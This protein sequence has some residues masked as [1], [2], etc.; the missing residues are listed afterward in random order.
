LCANFLDLE[1]VS[2]RVPATGVLL[3][4][5]P[6]GKWQEAGPGVYNASAKHASLATSPL[7]FD[8]LDAEGLQRADSTVMYVTSEC[9]LAAVATD[10]TAYPVLSTEHTCSSAQVLSDLVDSIDDTA[11]GQVELSFMV[12][13]ITGSSSVQQEVSIVDRLLLGDQPMGGRF[14]LEPPASAGAADPSPAPRMASALRRAV[15][16]VT[17][18]FGAYPEE[19]V[20]PLDIIR[21][22]YDA[23]TE[24]L[25]AFHRRQEAGVAEEVGDMSMCVSF[26]LGEVAG[27]TCMSMH[28][29]M[30]MSVDGRMAMDNESVADM[31][32]EIHLPQYSKATAT[33]HGNMT[34]TIVIDSD[35][36]APMGMYSQV[37][38]QHAYEMG[39][40]K[41]DGRGR[42]DWYFADTTNGEDGMSIWAGAWWHTTDIART[43]DM[44]FR[45]NMTDDDGMQVFDCGSELDWS[46]A[47]ADT[48][49]PTIDINMWM[50][51]WDAP[52]HITFNVEN[53][54]GSPSLYFMNMTGLDYDDVSFPLNMTGWLDL[55]TEVVHA[56]VWYDGDAIFHA[57]GTHTSDGSFGWTNVTFTPGPGMSLEDLAEGLSG[58]LGHWGDMIEEMSGMETVEEA[59]AFTALNTCNKSSAESMTDIHVNVRSPVA[60]RGYGVLAELTMAASRDMDV[61][62]AYTLSEFGSSTLTS[63]LQNETLAQE[64]ATGAWEWAGLKKSITP[65]DQMGG[66][67]MVAHASMN[68]VLHA[69]YGVQGLSDGNALGARLWFDQESSYDDAHMTAIPL[70]YRGSLANWWM[71]AGS[72]ADCTAEASLH[73]DSYTS[74]DARGAVGKLIGGG[75]ASASVEMASNSLNGARYHLLRSNESWPCALA[76]LAAGT[77]PHLCSGAV[78]TAFDRS[79]LSLALPTVSLGWDSSADFTPGVPGGYMGGV[80]FISDTSSQGYEPPVGWDS[81]DVESCTLPLAAQYWLH[82]DADSFSEVR[83]ALGVGS[84]AWCNSYDVTPRID[85]G[86]EETRII[87]S[88]VAS[89]A[90][91]DVRLMLFIEPNDQVA[92]VA[93]LTW[94]DLPAGS[95]WRPVEACGIMLSEGEPEF[96]VAADGEVHW[97]RTSMGA[98]MTFWEKHSAGS[99]A[100]QAVSAAS[101]ALRSATIDTYQTA[102]GTARSVVGT[103]T[104]SGLCASVDSSPRMV[105]HADTYAHAKKRDVGVRIEGDLV[106]D[107]LGHTVVNVTWQG[108]KDL[109]GVWREDAGMGLTTYDGGE[110]ARW[111]LVNASVRGDDAGSWV[112][113]TVSSQDLRV[114]AGMDIP[115]GVDDTEGRW[116]HHWFDTTDH[117]DTDTSSIDLTLNAWFP[118]DG[119]IWERTYFTNFTLDSHRRLYSR[120]FRWNDEPTTPQHTRIMRT[121]D[122]EVAVLLHMTDRMATQHVH[123]NVTGSAAE[124]VILYRAQ[125]WEVRERGAAIERLNEWE[126]ANYSTPTMWPSYSD[127]AA[128]DLLF[129]WDAVPH[130]AFLGN[131]TLLYDSGYWGSD[132]SYVKADQPCI[133][134]AAATWHL[135]G[136]DAFFESMKCDTAS[137]RLPDTVHLRDV[138]SSD[139]LN[140]SVL[141]REITEWEAH[142]YSTSNS[143]TSVNEFPQSWCVE[144]PWHYNQVVVDGMYESASRHTSWGSKREGDE[145]EANWCPSI[146]ASMSPES[147]QFSVGGSW[148]KAWHNATVYLLDGAHIAAG[149]ANW[150]VPQGDMNTQTIDACMVSYVAVEG[151]D[152]ADDSFSLHGHGY[153]SDTA[154]AEQMDMDL[155]LDNTT[156]ANGMSWADTY[157]ETTNDRYGDLFFA[158]QA[159]APAFLCTGVHGNVFTADVLGSSTYGQAPTKALAVFVTE[160]EN[161]HWW[162][163][164]ARWNASDIATGR[165]HHVDVSLDTRALALAAAGG[166]LTAVANLTVWN[167]TLDVVSRATANL[168]LRD[169]WEGSDR[170][171]MTIDA[172]PGLWW[173]KHHVGTT[174]MEMGLEM[175]PFDVEAHARRAGNNHTTVQAVWNGT[176]HANEDWSEAVGFHMLSEEPDNLCA[177]DNVKVSGAVKDSLDGMWVNVTLLMRSH[178]CEEEWYM[179]EESGNW[180]PYEHQESELTNGNFT[181][182]TPAHNDARLLANGLIHAFTLQGFPS[183]PA[184]T[185]QA[186]EAG[187]ALDVRPVQLSDGWFDY[188]HMVGAVHFDEVGKMCLGGDDTCELESEP[189]GGK[190]SVC[191]PRDSA[192]SSP[193]TVP[194]PDPSPSPI[195]SPSPSPAPSPSVG[196]PPSPTPSPSPSAAPA[197]FTVQPSSWSACS[198]A[199]GPSGVQTRTLT[200]LDEDGESVALS[201]CVTAPFPTE[202]ACNRQLCPDYHPVYGEYGEC[203][204]TCGGGEQYRTARC[205]DRSS[206]ATVSASRCNITSSDTY[207]ACNEGTCP[208]FYYTMGPWGRCSLA[209]GG[210][211]QTRAVNCTSST[212]ASTPI[213]A[214]ATDCGDATDAPATGRSCN[215]AP[216]TTYVVTVGSWGICGASGGSGC[217]DNVT[218]DVQ[219]VAIT[220]GERANAEDSACTAAGLSLP[221]YEQDCQCTFCELLELSG[222]EGACSGRGECGGAGVCTCDSGYGGD[223]CHIDNTCNGIVLNG[224]CCEGVVDNDG[225]CCGEGG[226]LDRE[227][228]CCTEGVDA[229]GVCGGSSTAMDI[230]GSCCMTEDLDASGL[231]CDDRID[232]LGICGGVD[233]GVL[234]IEVTVSTDLDSTV[235][236]EDSNADTNQLKAAL[237]AQ[238]ATAL[239]VDTSRVSVRFVASSGRRM[240]RLTEYRYRQLQASVEAVVE[241]QPEDAQTSNFRSLGD[242]KAALQGSSLVTSVAAVGMSATCGND[243]CEAGEAVVSGTTSGTECADDCPVPIAPCPADDDG[244][245]CGGAGQ[246]YCVLGTCECRNGYSGDACSSGCL[247]THVSVNGRCSFVGASHCSDGVKSG[248]ETGMDCGGSCVNDCPAG[249]DRGSTAHPARGDGTMTIVG[250]VV[251]IAAVGGIAALVLFVLRRQRGQNGN[252]KSVSVKNPTIVVDKPEGQAHIAGVNPMHSGSNSTGAAADGDRASL[253]IPLRAIRSNEGGD[254]S[255]GGREG[256]VK[257]SDEVS[258]DSATQD[259]DGPS[260]HYEEEGEDGSPDH[261]EEEEG[262]TLEDGTWYEV[263]TGYRYAPDGTGYWDGDDVWYGYE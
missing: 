182:H 113:M 143:S 232:S 69:G 246:G 197:V 166:V 191:T 211:V 223:R 89:P 177:Y 244:V 132:M 133:S 178:G 75:F 49:V 42:A 185:D 196:A 233:A 243:L 174:G 146:Q 9:R 242:V 189:Y 180:F 259:Q 150:T 199:C 254:S 234:E 14:T 241:V 154:A 184:P 41:A 12:W 263:S 79:A 1:F 162:A 262:Y 123:V 30:W 158:V 38:L 240:R 93:K 103:A 170:E 201:N 144:L 256:G 81:Y 251:G 205:E 225:E 207:R 236:L 4:R 219:C 92:V 70:R 126:A 6:A 139:H 124:D 80:L 160:T 216:C 101:A 10:G 202:Q 258:N 29:M 239:G 209:C 163:G 84:E 54:A 130:D 152:R 27:N 245:I 159:V 36:E 64:T 82:T 5:E 118:Y 252:N 8:L 106:S 119:A 35:G 120:A 77:S 78:T 151:G 168:T 142:L 40:S 116:M 125:E 100:D 51:E 11:S 164:D 169:G 187:V 32:M 181:V 134:N 83:S 15:Q 23:A 47:G 7:T 228:A 104:L 131:A 193:G 57:D 198:A 20:S 212:G 99:S 222:E 114:Y 96:A 249:Q 72:G 56:E 111:M 22:R 94:D 58:G 46:V 128:I 25:A 109:A 248:D 161:S 13:P 98:R 220:G 17:R 157:L 87:A 68:L 63:L 39:A 52:D 183:E 61:S 195:P 21:N 112:N 108:R 71:Q 215:S 250:V 138:H 167:H 237:A 73:S 50:G 97:S 127:G 67:K 59:V 247:S 203:S 179:D 188:M 217:G 226:D 33:L 148:S 107:E 230:A 55:D 172:R 253:A 214:G 171:G 192:S 66:R 156:S 149:K 145:D 86:N 165:K 122:L 3:G 260:D 190:A 224:E 62:C 48:R 210:G 208:S 18:P 229:C 140:V 115:T 137:Q 95:Q 45:A 221:S 261:Y 60:G 153:V 37:V 129:I 65:G 186:T 135:Q 85:Y 16:E 44:G 238:I 90:T 204:A 257:G 2:V 136:S 105:A 19:G 173:P 147:H 255:L 176:R 76:H 231:C 24:C 121:S 117:A 91:S 200:C 235:L 141:V 213:T 74:I 34:A 218:R 26:A 194:D 175:Q 43:G 110:P 155:A 28:D 31:S 88:G 206:G 53:S 227:G 102:L